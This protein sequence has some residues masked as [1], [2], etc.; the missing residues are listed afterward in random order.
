MIVILVKDHGIMEMYPEYYTGTDTESNT[1]IMY[2]Y[3]KT[4]RL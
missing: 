4:W 2:Q 1:G 3:I